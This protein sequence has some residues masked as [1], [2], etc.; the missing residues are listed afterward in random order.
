MSSSL[1]DD[2]SCP[3]CCELYQDPQLLSCGHSFCRRCLN[4]H[5]AVNPARAC[6]VCRQA[7][8]QQPVANLALRNT[9]ESYLKERERERESDVEVRCSL[10]EEKMIFFCKTAE[11]MICSQCRRYAHN[12]HRVQPLSHAVQQ[13][14]IRLKAALRPA[15]KALEALKNGTT[16]NT[17]ISKYIE[18]QAQRAEKLIKKEFEKFHQF[19]RDEE[20]A[21]ISALKKEVDRKR[22]KVQ[23]KIERE[24]QSLS[25]RVKEVEDEIKN[26]G[27]SFLQNFDHILQRAEYTEPD[28][29]FGSEN[30]I[31]MPEHVGNLGY[32]VWEKMTDIFHYYP[33]VLDPKTA[34]ADFSISDD[35]ASVAKTSHDSSIPIPHQGNRL[36]LG[37]KGYTGNDA[38]CWDV[39]V[40]DSKHWTVGMCL[41]SAEINHSAQPLNPQNGFWGLSRQGDSYRLLVPNANS[42][43]INRKLR[44]LRV[45]LG[46][47]FIPHNPNTWHGQ[48][49]LSFL[50][51]GDNSMI[52][53]TKVPTEVALFPLLIPDDRFSRLRI[54]PANVVRS[55]EHTFPLEVNK[56]REFVIAMCFILA[57]WI[58]S[59]LFKKE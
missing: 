46:W 32:R 9:C 38:D 54:S 56:I 43:R 44:I 33:V 48:R 12:S 11:K 1:E 58:I 50:D 20:E 8:P 17:R 31:N 35:L 40:G 21:R 47:R 39:E 52:A 57:V 16:R 23:E 45:Q 42:F 5:H 49:M 3:V 15:E 28:S 2:L 22:K 34:P 51:A 37:Y 36:V 26:D 6:A 25:E 7:S 13:R 18:S 19:L 4:K 41:R 59:I 10:H 53:F 27:A 24:I 55:V 30:L 14:K 29:Q